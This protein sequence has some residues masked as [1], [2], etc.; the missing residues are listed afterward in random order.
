MNTCATC[1]H[2]RSCDFSSEPAPGSIS[3]Q[4]QDNGGWCVCSKLSEPEY[5]STTTDA[6]T[7][8][9]FWTGN[10]FGCVHW[11]IVDAFASP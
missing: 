2:H 5:V 3:Q 10:D 8:G 7:K 9:G 11:K 4:M 6:D 1:I